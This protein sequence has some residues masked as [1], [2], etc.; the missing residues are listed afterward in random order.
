MA[1]VNGY[2]LLHFPEVENLLLCVLVCYYVQDFFIFDFL[3]LFYFFF[4]LLN[5]LHLFIYRF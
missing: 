3:R 2:P 1:L 5:P 4:K